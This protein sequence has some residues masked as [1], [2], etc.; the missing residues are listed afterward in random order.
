[1]AMLARTISEV[2]TDWIEGKEGAD[3]RLAESSQGDAR[4]HVLEVVRHQGGDYLAEQV[5]AELDAAE[6]NAEPDPAA[7]EHPR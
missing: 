2:I 3:K 6:S 4:S 1:M 7:A 5:E